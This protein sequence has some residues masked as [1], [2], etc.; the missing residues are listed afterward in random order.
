MRGMGQLEAAVMDVVWDRGDWSARGEVYDVLGAAGSLAYTTVLTSLVRLSRKGRLER[1][2][3][4]RAFA[5][6]A[7][8]SREAYA[9]DR[10]RQ[11]LAATTDPPLALRHFVAAL[12]AADRAQLLSVLTA[13]SETR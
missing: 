8:Q 12:S 13:R 4:G 11:L 7:T 9:A 1:Q 2:R 10:M 3:G 6:Q 5:Y